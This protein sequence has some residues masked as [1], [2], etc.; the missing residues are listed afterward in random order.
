MGLKK[1]YSA[2][3]V[4]ASQAGEQEQ[5]YVP[6]S[7]LV[8]CSEQTKDDD[9]DDVLEGCIIHPLYSG[10]TQAMMYNLIILESTIEKWIHLVMILLTWLSFTGR[11]KGSDQ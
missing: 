10:K 8:R 6:I 11:G 3:T 9:D 5:N 4:C 2:G 1:S 7:L